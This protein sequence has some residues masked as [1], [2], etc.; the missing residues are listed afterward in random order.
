MFARGTPEGITFAPGSFGGISWS[1]NAYHPGTGLVYVPALHMPA[2][3]FEES[4]ADGQSGETVSYLATRYADD[5]EKWGTLSAIDS[6]ARGKIAWQVKTEQL[7]VGGVL[8]TAGDLV[9]FGEGNGRFSAL[10]AE[11]GETLW[12]Y[13]GDAGINAPAMTYAVDGHQFVAIA[14]GGSRFYGFAP[15]DSI[16]AFALPKDE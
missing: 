11:S 8:A 12:H 10:D 6:R 15:G 9:F 3:L 14:A 13:Q 16:L 1:P 5:G 4:I 7:L 2:M